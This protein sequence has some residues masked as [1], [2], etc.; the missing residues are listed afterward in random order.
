VLRAGE[1]FTIPP[2]TRHWFAA[3]ADGAVV[4]E[5]SS[6]SRDDLDEFT[7]PRVVRAPAGAPSTTQ[8]T[9]GART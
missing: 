4:S 2:D 3:G 9:P 8:L 7:D 1:Q 5:F 6:T